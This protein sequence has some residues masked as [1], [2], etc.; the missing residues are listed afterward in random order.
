MSDPEALRFSSQPIG[1]K[2]LV[3]HALCSVCNVYFFPLQASSIRI[4]TFCILA[5]ACRCMYIIRNAVFFDPSTT[6]VSSR[7]PPITLSHYVGEYWPFGMTHIKEFMVG[8]MLGLLCMYVQIGGFISPDGAGRV[9]Q[10]GHDNLTLIFFHALSTSW[11][12]CATKKTYNDNSIMSSAWNVIGPYLVIFA[13]LSYVTSPDSNLR[14]G[15]SFVFDIQ[16]PTQSFLVSSLGS[17]IG[18]LIALGADMVTPKPLQPG[19]RVI[20]KAHRTN[21][22]SDSL[23]GHVTN[24]T[25]QSGNEFV[26]SSKYPM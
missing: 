3:F 8:N 16:Y 11:L 9:L 23:T 24:I 12:I 18:T 26:P 25:P 22:L 19:D 15:V 10:I 2:M 13:I 17:I 4:A 1:V 21:G 5:V 14:L 20:L 6:R 7:A